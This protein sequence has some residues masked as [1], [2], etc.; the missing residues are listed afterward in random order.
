MPAPS[1]A[2]FSGLPVF[3]CVLCLLAP[4]V[5]MAAPVNEKAFQELWSLHMGSPDDHQAVDT[6]CGT[7]AKQ[8]AADPLIPAVLEIKAWHLLKAGKT[9]EGAD[10]FRSLVSGGPDPVAAGAS[11]VAKGWLTRFDR[12]PLLPALRAYYRQEVGYPAKLS[13][14]FSHPKVS[15]AAKLPK[16]DRFGEAWDYRL[17]GFAKVAGFTNQRYALQ[18]RRLGPLTDLAAALKAPYGSSIESKPIKIVDGTPKMVTFKQ[19]SSVGAVGPGQEWQGVHL[20]YLGERFLMV[21]NATS[22]MLFPTPHP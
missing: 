21:C 11:L 4:A 2:S 17:T 6:A 19:G 9:Q 7:F 14:L 8:N 3:A 15:E 12:E 5:S 1:P 22:W 13:E 18:S 20:A 10:I 16:T